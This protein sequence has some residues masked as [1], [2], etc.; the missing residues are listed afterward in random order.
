MLILNL[1]QHTAFFAFL[2]Q[3][4]MQM[5]KNSLCIIYPFKTCVCYYQMYFF[6]HF[7]SKISVLADLT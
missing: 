6:L 3:F 4:T 1:N 7:F 2:S 5:T